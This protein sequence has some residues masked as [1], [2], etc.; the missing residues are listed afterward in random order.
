MITQPFLKWGYRII[1]INK[2]PTNALIIGRFN[3]CVNRSTILEICKTLDMEQ[4]LDYYK[5][6]GKSD[7]S[8]YQIPLQY[9]YFDRVN[10]KRL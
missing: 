9:I 3:G 4:L 6:T 10:I 8:F 7:L 1:N 2:F 5:V